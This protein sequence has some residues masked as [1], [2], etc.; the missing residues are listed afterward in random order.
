MQG[1][2]LLNLITDAEKQIVREILEIFAAK[3]GI[4]FQE[5]LDA[6]QFNQSNR[7][8]GDGFTG[9]MFHELG[10]AIALGHAYDLPSIM[11][12]GLPNTVL[13]GDHDWVHL[14]RALRPDAT[15]IDLYQ[16]N[17]VE[18]GRFTAEITAERL[19]PTSLLNSVLTLFNADGEVVAR[20]D[21]YYSVDAFLNIDLAKGTYYVGV[22][23]TGNDKYDPR[24]ANS[25]FGGTTDGRYDLALGFTPSISA[26][27]RDSDGTS[28]DGDANGSPGGTH[29]FWF[30]AS[31]YTIFVDKNAN[32]V[33]NQVDGAG[34]LASPFDTISHPQSTSQ[35][36]FDVAANRIIVPLAGGAAFGHGDRFV[37]D[38]KFH[39]PR[40]FTFDDGSGGVASPS[41]L[42][43]ANPDTLAQRIY[44]AI[45]TELIALNLT[46]FTVTRDAINRPREVRLSYPATLDVS[47]TAAL[48]NAPNLVRIVGNGGIDVDLDSR[49][50][51]QP[52]LVGEHHQTAAALADGLEFLVPQGTTV[53]VDGGTLFKLRKA[54]LDAGTSALGNDRRAGAIQLLGTPHQPVLLRSFHDDTIGG[55]SDGVGPVPLKG[56]FGG[57]VFRDDS[58]LESLGVFLNQVN[59]ADIRHG[60]G[61]VFV[62]SVESAFSPVF[63][64]DA[65]PTSAFSRISDSED[66]ALSA[67][68]NSFDD[69]LGRNGPDV[70]GNYLSGNTINGLSV[71]VGTGTD[72]ERLSVT[73][74]WDDTDITHVLTQNLQLAGSP[75]GPLIAREVQ[76]I[77]ITGGTPTSGKFNLRFTDHL[78]TAQT[79]ADVAFNAPA[80]QR[81]NKTVRLSATG[82]T[83]GTFRLEFTKRPA[84][85][86]PTT[87]TTPAAPNALIFSAT[88]S[89]VKTALEGLSNIDPGDV[90]VTGGPL[91]VAPITIE[92]TGALAGTTPEGLAILTADLAVPTST[93]VGAVASI[94]N[95]TDVVIPV[96]EHLENLSN[97]LPGDV[98][99]TGGPLPTAPITVAF[100]N[101]F[102]SNNLPPMQVLTPT[103]NSG[104]A[105]VA[106]VS[107]GNLSGRTS[108]R[109]A[110]DPGV[111]VKL[112][113][114]RIELERGAS[115]LIA[116]GTRNEP[117]I[118][119]SINDDRFGGSG[120]F[121]VTNG[122]VSLGAKGDWSGLMFN[123]VSS[124]SIDHALITFAGGSS[125]IEGTSATFN[126]IEVHQARLRLANSV[127]E[128]NAGVAAGSTRKG[129]GSNDAATI[130]VRG[131]QPI[132][133]N[134]IIRHN[135]GSVISINANALNSV[136]LADYGR[137]TGGVDAFSELADNFGPLVRLNRLDNVTSN[138][139]LNGLEV[140]AEQLT[141][142]SIWDDTDI[143]H[144]LRGNIRIDNQHTFNGLKL[145]SS[146]DESLVVK[147][148]NP[149]VGTAGFT[150][151][152]TLLD[153]DDRIGGTLH[154]LG[155]IGHPVILT[156]LAD[157]TV[158]AGFTPY[159]RVLS[160]T[161]NNGSAST[162]APGD[163]HS[164]S[165]QEYSNDRNVALVREAENPLTDGNDENATVAQLLGDLAQDFKNGNEVQRLGF[166]VRGFVSPN[167][168]TDVDLYSFKGAAGTEVWIDI[169]RASP[170]LDVVVELLDGT[171]TVLARAVN[172]TTAPTGSAAP[173]DM[174]ANPL[175]G[176][177]FYSQ[178]VSDPGMRLVLPGTLGTTPTYFVRV[179]SNPQ[180]DNLITD[181]D[182]GLTAGKYQLQIRMRQVDEFPGSASQYADIRYA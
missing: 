94:T 130:F 143:V 174:F 8:F 32:V 11:G 103:L 179:R 126:P 173:G 9:V 175:L 43:H 115:A 57:V 97:I 138:S 79:T 49:G 59:H 123:H 33:A 36:A 78:G 6:A 159:G 136:E 23:S 164:I 82:A 167:D 180:P 13:P 73:A 16:F 139:A 153:I 95:V 93:L 29:Q 118:F 140:R 74:R 24:V 168:P 161:N 27:L 76:T 158:G 125:A 89:D 99:V 22:T 169:D 45:N 157:D 137:A 12:S 177:D 182:G 56:D 25:G 114:A 117:I 50:D 18:P 86:A 149:T 14:Q 109:L 100:V 176:G 144:I 54:N 90:V 151:D 155:T 106:T 129:R 31:D 75:G 66:N 124:G 85:G 42:L 1:N 170:A 60:G 47:G 30:E 55:N 63:L 52:Y 133:V 181:L 17:L 128:Q 4:E 147:L 70:H 38:D 145:Q 148:A 7:E 83:A 110:I 131:A 101:T 119:T 154:I 2:P 134:N 39:S 44:G 107:D 28:I 68:P 53:V 10:H 35:A 46:G 142:E 67:N 135:T 163:W 71:R 40:T 113:T 5:V 81:T 112:G 91:N 172:S 15:D 48:I 61:R 20:N 51:N 65:R 116:E 62:A 108:G 150:V 127:V 120:T 156:S 84:L 178:N 102:G 152:G 162:P 122:G 77:S 72:I 37:I 171:Q 64:D 146:N 69:S 166:E 58:D 92:F 87:D 111:V 3:T 141:T 34:T 80:D 132:I 21:D 165:L 98:I 19:A 105:I 96:R 41:V 88:A 160:D 104:A 26:E 121:D